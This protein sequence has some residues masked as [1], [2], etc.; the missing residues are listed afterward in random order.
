MT[1]YFDNNATTAIAPESLEA[2]WPFLRDHYGNPSSPHAYARKPA[3]A[4][5][6]AREQVAALIGAPSQSVVFTSGGTESNAMAIHAALAARPAR[7]DVI[8][9]GVEHAA[10]WGWRP[11]LEAQGFRVHVV[12]VKKSGELD[13]D[14]LARTLS[15]DVA[16]VSVMLANNETGIIYPIQQITAMAH[17]AGA[18]VHTDAVQAAGKISMSLVELGVDYAAVCGHKCHAVKGIGALY[19]RD[20]H[21][22]EPLMFGG[23]QESGRR[24]GTE[25]VPQIVSFGA[26]AALVRSLPEDLGAR[27]DE[28]ERWLASTFPGV[29]IAGKNQPRLPNTTLALFPG[30]ETEPLLALLDMHGVACSSGSACA[31]G[32]HEPSHVLAAMKLDHI[33]AAVVR[34]SSSRYTTSEDDAKLRYAL[35]AS[36]TQ[37]TSSNR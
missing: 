22:F 11:R 10:V 6:S 27:R 8:F 28:L 15:P 3:M 33:R 13:L 20:A 37:L 24:P 35:Q 23:E 19:V 9:S 31:S 16:L 1:A 30:I 34:I 2:M 25:S 7:R 21:G 26:A 29:I 17:A 12:P 18:R 36:I 14:Y 5:A 4:I 32:A